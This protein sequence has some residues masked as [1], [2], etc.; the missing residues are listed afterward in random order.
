MANPEK[1]KRARIN[2]IERF[3]SNYR[4]FPHSCKQR[5]QLEARADKIQWFVWDCPPEPRPHFFM[6]AYWSRMRE[7]C[8]EW[9]NYDI[10]VNCTFFYRRKVGKKLCKQQITKARSIINLF[11]CFPIN[12]VQCMQGFQQK[13]FWYF[14][15][16]FRLTPG[17]KVGVLQPKNQIGSTAIS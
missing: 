9:L 15:I 11:F 2:K 13:I 5:H 3:H 17:L 7:R 1:S 4:P 8:I 16:S 10:W 14:V 12:E 6:F